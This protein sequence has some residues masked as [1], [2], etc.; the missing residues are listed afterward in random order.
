MR[1]QPSLSRRSA[2]AIGFVLKDRADAELVEAVRSAA[3][4]I[5]ARIHVSG[6]GDLSRLSTRWFEKEAVMDATTPPEI[7]E[8]EERRARMRLAACRA[9]L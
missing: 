3:R 1:T 2:G 9:E 6:G 7:L 4:G 8:E 5:A